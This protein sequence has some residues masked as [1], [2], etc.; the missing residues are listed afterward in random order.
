M[1]EDGAYGRLLDSYYATEKALDPAKVNNTARAT[2]A[3]ERKAVADVVEAFF[4]LGEDGLLHNEKADEELGIAIPKLERLRE[5]AHENGKK[6]GNPK[7]KEQYNEPG[8]LYAAAIGNGRIKVGITA[9]LAQRLSGLRGKH[10]SCVVSLLQSVQV[11]EMG[12]AEARLLAEFKQF[13]D[14]EILV[15]MT[16]AQAGEM[17]AFMASLGQVTHPVTQP[18]P[19]EIPHPD[20]QPIPAEIRRQPSTVSHQP[21]P[22]SDNR[23]PGGGDI[24]PPERKADGAETHVNPDALAR[25][26]AE[27]Q[28]A[29]VQDAGPESPI[30]ARWV[31]NGATPTHVAN[32]CVEARK[33]VHFP[34]PLAI[35]Y[36]DKILEPMVESDRKARAN[37]EARVRN[38]KAQL[39]EQAKWESSPMPDH[40]KPRRAAGA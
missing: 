23:F 13:A 40:L 29:Q 8:T 12:K 20:P 36:V 15:G 2:T 26:V 28:R 32:A 3:A 6:G 35:G 5:V 31:R 30:I 14:G 17:L 25:I 24:P 22:L 38:T 16:A 9:H 19:G 37:A 10:K 4:Y 33:S 39:G 21:E 27:C 7:K 18:E 34:K 1:I 11:P